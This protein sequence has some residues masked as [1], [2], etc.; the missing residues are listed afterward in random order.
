VTRAVLDPGVLVS[1]LISPGG[2]PAKLLAAANAGVFE[3]IISP[4]LMEELE[5]VLRRDKFRRYVEL[6]T[7]A[8]YL[9]FLKQESLSVDDP[10]APPPIRSEDPDDNYLIALAQSQTAALVSGD[11][12]LLAL[13]GQIP[14]FPPAEFLAA[15]QG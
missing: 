15:N 9:A 7:V 11:R 13:A 2:A 14:V 3:L 4:L 10:V 12:H 8:A 5:A 6:D 1:A